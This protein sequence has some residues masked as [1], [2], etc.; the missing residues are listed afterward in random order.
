MWKNNILG[1]ETPEKLRETVLFLL[2]I[3]LGLCAGDEHYAL[4]RG[5]KDKPSQL[6]FE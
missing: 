2:G 5:T 6:S 1:E 4:R 3:N